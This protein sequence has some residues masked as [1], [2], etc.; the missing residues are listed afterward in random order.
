MI[1]YGHCTEWK[2]TLLQRTDY[3]K[4]LHALQIDNC[5]ISHKD[6]GQIKHFFKHCGFFWSGLVG[7][8]LIW[9]VYGARAPNHVYI[10]GGHACNRVVAELVVLGVCVQLLQLPNTHAGNRDG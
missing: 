7:I 8:W 9:L 4:A 5:S 10:R 6:T 1:S 3:V 2:I